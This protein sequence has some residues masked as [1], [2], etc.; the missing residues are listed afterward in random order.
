MLR[1]NVMRAGGK[2]FQFPRGCAGIDGCF[3]TAAGGFQVGGLARRPEHSCS[4]QDDNVAAGPEFSAEH[5]ADRSGAFGRTSHGQILEPCGRL[6]RQ[7]EVLGSP[8][9]MNRRDR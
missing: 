6:R 8:A 5:R 9:V 3:C 7:A 1:G 4:I 2:L